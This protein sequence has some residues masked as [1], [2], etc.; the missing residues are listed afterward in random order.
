M[1][2]TS[3][4]LAAVSVP[5]RTAWKY[6]LVRFLVNTAM[7]SPSASAAL[8]KSAV[9]TAV[10]LM[11]RYFILP[12]PFSYSM[13]WTVGNCCLFADPTRAGIDPNREQD[14]EA[15]DERL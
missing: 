7:V 1:T 14:D 3:S 5:T 8:E 12:T 10:T 9:S 11:T 4:V 13:W 15:G 6:G 2:L